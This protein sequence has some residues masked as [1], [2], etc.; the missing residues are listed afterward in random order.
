MKYW[1]HKTAQGTIYI[2]HANNEYDIM[3]KRNCVGTYDD[4]QQAVDDL[5]SG[6]AIWSAF[7]D[8]STLDIPEEIGE[9]KQG[10]SKK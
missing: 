3:F 7:G 5:V 4:P 9:W 6:H 1:Y 8:P 2:V 10:Q